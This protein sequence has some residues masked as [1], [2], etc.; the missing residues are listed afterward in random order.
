[1]HRF[2]NRT[3]EYTPYVVMA[4]ED[5]TPIIY[6]YDEKLE[7]KHFLDL[8]SDRHDKDTMGA[9]EVLSASNGVVMTF[10]KI[11]SELYDREMEDV[12]KDEE[13]VA[14]AYEDIQKLSLTELKMCRKFLAEAHVRESLIYFHRQ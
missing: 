8:F 1:M 5:I 6:T 14:K 7:K 9:V 2:L 12:F 4:L 13:A 11:V 3:H 10:S